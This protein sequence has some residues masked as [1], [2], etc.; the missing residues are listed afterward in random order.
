MGRT[1]SLLSSREVDSLLS[2]LRRVSVLEDL[3]IRDETARFQDCLVSILPQPEHT[4]QS[5]SAEMEEEDARKSKE[6]VVLDRRIL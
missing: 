3:K 5:T 1:S 6:D 4:H 2:N